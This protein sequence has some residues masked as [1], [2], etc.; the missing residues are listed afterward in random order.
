M[1]RAFVRAEN[2]RLHLLQ[3][4]RD[5]TLAADRRLLAGVMRRHACQVRFRDLDEIT[6]DRIETDLERLDPGARDLAF[7]QFGDPVLAFARSVAAIHR[8]RR[9]KPSRKI[10]PSFKAS[11]GSST[12]AALSFAASSGISL[13]LI[14]QYVRPD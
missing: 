13:N 14:L 3:L 7:L 12:S 1:P 2:F 5:E 4:R 8:D 9:S 10:P 6:E 11:G